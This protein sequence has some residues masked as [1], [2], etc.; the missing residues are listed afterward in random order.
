MTIWATR[1]LPQRSDRA[2]KVW[3]SAG[4]IR[5]HMIALVHAL[6]SQPFIHESAPTRS[7]RRTKSILDDGGPA[8]DGQ[9]GTNARDTAHDNIDTQKR[10]NCPNGT[11]WPMCQ[12]QQ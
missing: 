6:R 2:A 12:N 10:S 7:R 1:N 3:I 9:R 5:S 8:P 4:A 11:G